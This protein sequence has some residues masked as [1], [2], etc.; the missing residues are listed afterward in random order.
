LILPEKINFG[1]IDL[2]IIGAIIKESYVVAGRYIWLMQ[3][4]LEIHTSPPDIL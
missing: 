4:P 1:T 3:P 2:T